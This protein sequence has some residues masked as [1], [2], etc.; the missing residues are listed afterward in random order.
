MPTVTCWTMGMN[1][2]CCM[3]SKPF[4]RQLWMVPALHT[5]TAPP[6]WSPIILRGGLALLL[7]SMTTIL[8]LR[9]MTKENMMNR[10]GQGWCFLN[11]L[12]AA[13]MMLYDPLKCSGLTDL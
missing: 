3:P 2:S 8:R 13:L 11:L 5:N 4:C 1:V 6:S 10:A 9:I 7:Q 12:F